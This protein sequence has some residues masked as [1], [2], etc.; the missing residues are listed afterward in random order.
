[1]KCNKYSVIVTTLCGLG[2]L[3]VIAFAVLTD[4]SRGTETY[5]I[6]NMEVTAYCPCEKCCG[7]YADDITASGAVAEGFLVAAPPD[8]PFGTRLVIPGYNSGL[9]VEVKDRGGAIKG[10][11]LDILFPTHQEAL[12]WGRQKINVRF[13]DK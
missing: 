3:L 11:R 9:P 4:G 10:D 8:I 13:L 1:M 2:F 5:T 12:N 7:K 6:K